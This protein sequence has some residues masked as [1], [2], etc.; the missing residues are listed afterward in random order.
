LDAVWRTLVAS[1]F[2]RQVAQT[3]GVR[4]V[5]MV[6]GMVSS[7]LLARAL[8][9][10]GRGLFAVASTLLA[11]GI[12]FGNLGL[13]SSNTYQVAREPRSLP[14]LLANSLVLSLVL[15]T[16]ICAVVWGI[17]WARPTMLGLPTPVL[18]LAMAAIPLGMAYLL[19]QN[20]LLGVQDVGTYNR[21]E[22]VTRIAFVILI[23]VACWGGVATVSWALV[24]GLVT[25]AA[26]FLWAW[27]ALNRRIAQQLKVPVTISWPLFKTNLRYGL[28]VYIV[29][30]CGYLILKVDLLMVN[31]LAGTEQAGY[32]SISSALADLLYMLPSTICSILFPRLSAISDAQQRWKLTVRAMLGMC[33]VM[34]PLAV[35]AALLA[36][37]AVRTLYGEA[38]LPAATPFMILCASM[39]FYSI[40]TVIS[41]YLSAIGF[42]PAVIGIWA[43]VALLNLGLNAVLIPRF[44]IVGAAWS[45]LICYGAILALQCLYTWK[46]L[47]PSG[48]TATA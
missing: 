17:N 42:P 9:P 1:T 47:K 35:V 31:G 25:A 48:G 19:L 41:N 13:P 2:A 26:A 29:T 11:L 37:W 8:G 40:S 46:N 28:K 12:Q 27:F 34:V 23:L 22:F 10:Q 44:N 6:A 3:Y 24:A 21:I 14:S 18:L 38:F 39:V 4:V 43:V 30:L 33:A 15:G 5:V 20:L 16:V 36:P 45:S 32:Y 7:I